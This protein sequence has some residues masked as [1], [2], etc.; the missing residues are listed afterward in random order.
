M[1]Q[2]KTKKPHLKPCT[3]DDSTTIMDLLN[4][5]GSISNR[6]FVISKTIMMGGTPHRQSISKCRIYFNPDLVFPAVN[7]LGNCDLV[8]SQFVPNEYE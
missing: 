2:L 1:L 6:E 8:D 5:V 7:L 3:Q 4:T